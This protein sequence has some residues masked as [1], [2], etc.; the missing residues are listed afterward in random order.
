MDG[1]QDLLGVVHE[2][3]RTLLLHLQLRR[4][5]LHQASR[6]LLWSMDCLPNLPLLTSHLPLKAI[7]RKMF[8]Q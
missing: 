2:Q 5:S 6:P 3:I 8:K 4:D 1:E 7:L